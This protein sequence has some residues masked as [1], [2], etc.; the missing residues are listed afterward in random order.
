MANIF[1]IGPSMAIPAAQF[2]FIK[3]NPA[4]NIYW[5]RQFNILKKLNTGE[6]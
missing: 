5:A 2:I 1:Q 4:P 3:H 6:V